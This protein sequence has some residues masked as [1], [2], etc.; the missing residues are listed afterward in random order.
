MRE[1]RLAAKAEDGIGFGVFTLEGAHLDVGPASARPDEHLY[2]CVEQDVEPIVEATFAPLIEKIRRDLTSPRRPDP[3]IRV[4][5][6]PGLVLLLHDRH[7]HGFGPR[8]LR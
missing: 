8:D 2:P 6:R 3:D 4:E 5:H 1:G 7:T